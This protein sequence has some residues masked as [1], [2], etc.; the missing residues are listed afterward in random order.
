[1]DKFV[2]LAKQ[3]VEKYVKTGKTLEM[4][5]DLPP[6]F[7]RKAGVFV[8][9]KKGEALRGCVGTYLPTQENLA[10]EIIS[11]AISACAY[12]GRFYPISEEELPDLSY[13]VSVLSKPQKILSL[14]KHNPKKYGLIVVGSGGR[15]G[16]LL[17]DLEGIDT[18]EEQRVIACQKGGIDPR[19][20][21]IEYYAFTVEKHI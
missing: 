2:A 5:A 13:E 3:A 19:E 17:P 10:R 16:L 14:E 21:E 15:R 7:L 11:S 20:T 8:T 12:D 1:M 18:A 9:I 6:E 4:P